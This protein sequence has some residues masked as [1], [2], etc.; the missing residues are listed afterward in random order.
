MIAHAA[1]R[2]RVVAAAIA[3]SSTIELGHGIAG[4]WLPG[5]A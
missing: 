2:R 4:S 1:R 3:E 5:I